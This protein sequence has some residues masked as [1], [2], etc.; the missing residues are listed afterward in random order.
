MTSDRFRDLYLGSRVHLEWLQGDDAGVAPSVLRIPRDPQH[1]IC[2]LFAE[3]QVLDGGL[4]L[5]L[6]RSS[7]AHLQL[8]AV[9]LGQGGLAP[10]DQLHEVE[11]VGGA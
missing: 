9:N 5:E 10:L 4:G 8:G 7:R 11:A 6:A 2:E 1:V 3:D